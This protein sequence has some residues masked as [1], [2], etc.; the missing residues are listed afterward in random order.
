LPG[1]PSTPLARSIRS[2]IFR[3]L[4]QRVGDVRQLLGRIAPGEIAQHERT[5]PGTAG[6]GS[7][8]AAA[9]DAA[10]SASPNAAGKRQ[11]QAFYIMDLPDMDAAVEW[12]N[13]LPTY[14]YVE[15]RELLQF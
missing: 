10:S 9:D 5:R 8:A 4:I 3:R 2:Y 7:T 11:I 14:G 12:A 15:V 1:A 6:T 13:T